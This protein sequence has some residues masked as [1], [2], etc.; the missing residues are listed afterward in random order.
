MP[1]YNLQVKAEL[2][3]VEQ[4]QPASAAEY[5]FHLLLACAHCKEST[6]KHVNFSLQ[7]EADIPGGRGVANFVA[8]C[9]LCSRDFSIEI[10][11][12]SIVPYKSSSNNGFATIASFECRGVELTGF[13]PA[14]GW[15]VVAEETGTTFTDVD[16]SEEFAEYDEKASEP[17]GISS[18]ESRF[19]VSK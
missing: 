13:E 15:T 18:L 19:V 6:G 14:S 8:K 5:E 12:G 3:R 2:A 4:F 16:L 10:I 9:K 1:K 17:V 7:D 11:K